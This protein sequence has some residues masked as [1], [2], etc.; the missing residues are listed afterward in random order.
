MKCKHAR[1][2]SR[3]GLE[4]WKNFF[5]FRTLKNIYFNYRSP[6]IWE[7]NY[8]L[9]NRKPEEKPFYTS[10]KIYIEILCVYIHGLEICVIAS[11]IA[12]LLIVYTTMCTS[13]CECAI[14]KYK[15][16]RVYIHIYIKREQIHMIIICTTLIRENMP[17][18]FVENAAFPKQKIFPLSFFCCCTHAVLF[19][20]SVLSS[21]T[22]TGIC[23]FCEYQWRWWWRWEL[24]ILHYAERENA[25]HVSSFSIIFL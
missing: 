18:V 2:P 9:H 1:I 3:N 22:K 20:L 23:V 8:F 4:L 7:W 16:R 15:I 21:S 12:R 25:Q 24:N 11:T 5:C 13:S 6:I 10:Q 19:C 14:I 17:G